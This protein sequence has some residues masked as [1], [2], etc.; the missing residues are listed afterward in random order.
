MS[1]EFIGP[2]FL[3]GVTL[4][5]WIA[6]GLAPVEKKPAYRGIGTVLAVLTIAV[7]I[8][9]FIHYRGNVVCSLRSA[10]SCQRLQPPGTPTYPGTP[11]P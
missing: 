7:F 1:A 2:L 4:C 11:Y 9:T 8:L 3:L 10:S 5:V 6:W